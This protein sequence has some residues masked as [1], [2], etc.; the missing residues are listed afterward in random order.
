MNCDRCK[1]YNWYYDWC[2]KWMCEVDCRSVYN[3]FTLGIQG[4]MDMIRSPE[5]VNRI[6]K[7][8]VKNIERLN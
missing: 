6:F 7:V 5:L 3:C 8:N 4:G 1:H 2:K